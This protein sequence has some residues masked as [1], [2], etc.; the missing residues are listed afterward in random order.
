M[1]A[2]TTT[3]TSTE[4]AALDETPSPNVDEEDSEDSDKKE[5]Q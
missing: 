5:A 3:T 4:D 2:R 1:I